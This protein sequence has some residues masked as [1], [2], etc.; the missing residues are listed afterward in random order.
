MGDTTIE[1]V[2]DGDNGGLLIAQKATLSQTAV[3]QSISFYVRVARGNLVLGVYDATGS[4][5][6]PGKLITQ[7]AAFTPH[8]GWNTV[9][10]EKTPTLAPGTYW[11]SYHPQSNSLGFQN[12]LGTGTEVHV[13]RSYNVVMPATFPNYGGVRG[14]YNDQ[15][16]FYATLDTTAPPPPPPTNGVCGPANDAPTA[17]APTTNLC[18]AG[19][20]TTVMGTGPWTWTCVGANGGTTAS[21]SA[22]VGNPPP[23]PAVQV[24][25]PS[26][27][28]FNSP[29]YQCNANYYVASN[30]SDSNNGS[31]A[32]PWLTL[33]HADSANVGPGACI[34]IA[35]GTYDGF[36]V[37]NGGSAALAGGYVVY[38]CTTMDACNINGN[39]G[40]NGSGA[41]SLGY[42]A[43][44]V[45]NYVMFD[46]LN[47][48]GQA[49]PFYSWG[50]ATN[51]PTN[52]P[53]S[54]TV[55]NHHIWVLNSTITN[56]GQAGITFGN[57]D[58]NYAIHNKSYGNSNLQ[59]D[60]QGSGIGIVVAMAVPGYTPTADDQNNPNPMIGSLVNPNT[61][62]GASDG[63][64][65]N[66]IAWNV[67]FNN[68]LT[69]CGT[70]SNP[71]DT[72]GNGI[73]LDTLTIDNDNGSY[74]G[75]TLIDFNVVY[76]NGGGGV[77]VFH[78]AYATVANNSCYNNYIDPAN[79]GEGGC[80]DD[81][82]GFANTYLNNIAIAIPAPPP[83]GGCQ[84]ST[85]PYPMW[86][87]ALLLS[88]SGSP[89]DVTA[90]NIT[91]SR[92]AGAPG[93]YGEIAEF[94]NGF[95]MDPYSTTSNLVS[96][97][98]QWV[99]VGTV[100]AGTESTPPSGTNFALQPT[101]PAIGFGVTKP[102]LPAQSVDVGACHHSLTSCP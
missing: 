77:H 100:S 67:V 57:G 91:Q 53:G 11:L 23:P 43:N 28:L 40:P 3:L 95:G 64:F 90:S 78:S 47:L 65:H 93:C 101:S 49:N 10:T 44:T 29:Y 85:P 12:A 69:Q 70:V 55:G 68:A 15:W 13:T 41:I 14:F 54:G 83:S 1:A 87:S 17:S 46:G 35:P 84:Y 25:G 30:G 72:D 102:Y 71:Y 22:P 19:S 38:R 2:N 7:A 97:D 92:G 4:G 98:P 56:F 88:P 82:N 48:V 27:A 73:I 89:I 61:L 63:Y 99:D 34:N 33:Q 37:N 62:S 80:I 96:T 16:S 42:G 75:Q 74:K 94:D 59:C 9:P 26:L 32:A 24:P 76:N 79:Q 36:T 51:N 81:A 60:A 31:Q 39:A 5:A 66:V 21:C 52:T 58:F 18:T 86:D 20:A 6:G 50:L 8:T 45:A